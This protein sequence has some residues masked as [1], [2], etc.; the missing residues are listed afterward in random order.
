MGTAKPMM[1]SYPDLAGRGVALLIA[2]HASYSKKK[3]VKIFGR[4]ILL[5]TSLSLF[6]VYV[7]S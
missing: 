2:N 3:E 7:I 4:T 6:N 5:C 1:Y